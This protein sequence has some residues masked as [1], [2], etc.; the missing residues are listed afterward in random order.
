M[1]KIIKKNHNLI[2]LL[3]SVIFVL[4]AVLS[5]IHSG[6]PLTDDGN[7]MVIRFSA[8]FENLRNGQFP[9]RFLTRLNNGFGYPVSDFL[10]PLFM[11]LGVPIHLLGI[12][13]VN[14]IKIIFSLSLI[15]SSVF[16][17]LWLRKIFDNISSFIGAIFYTLF[18]Y[19]LYDIYKRGS[20][21]EALA[22]AILPFILWQIERRNLLLTSV[23]IGFLILSHNTLSLLFIPLVLAYALF[24][25]KNLLRFIFTSIFFGFGV[26]SFFWI[27]AIYDTR[28]TVFAG[29]Q[30][31]D[32]FKYF[33]NLRDFGIIGVV[34]LVLLFSSTF[35]I[36]IKSK[37]RKNKLFFY[38]LIASFLVIFFT[39]P[40]SRPLWE[41]IPLTNL[42]QFPFRLL[43]LLIIL[44]TFQLS[45]LINTLDKNKKI[46]VTII[47][48]TPIY[49]SAK[50]YLFTQNYQYFPDTFYSTNQSTTTV[51]NEYM[52][53]WVKKIPDKTA[54]AK[55]EN[56]NGQEKINIVN[57]NPNKIVFDTFVLTDRIIRVNTVY[58][59]GWNVYANGR[60]VKINYENNGLIQ[61]KLNKG[62]NNVKVVFE[63]TGVRILS[64]I[65]SIISVLGLLFLG[66]LITIK[67]FKI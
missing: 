32:F 52:P 15:F 39:S 31:S 24:K 28:Y 27:P 51:R 30:V 61:F 53:K 35:L 8:F 37:T 65:L 19:H 7:W 38:S 4:P 55:V 46:L 63:E 50:P 58:F 20:I 1:L 9:V 66:Y 25:N 43:S 11:Y 21:G 41:F 34:S 10:Y 16:T 29:T 17:Y 47:F 42:I 57:I 5:L 14:T 67:R 2:F 40:F 44:L 62:Q 26:A 22:L 13:F 56:I 45:F 54:S 59:P 23:G 3:L 48:L 60:M 18:P 6:F 33:I 36:F 49:V 64:D 12:S